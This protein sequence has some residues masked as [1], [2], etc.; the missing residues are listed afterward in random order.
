MIARL[1]VG[2]SSWQSVSGCNHRREFSRVRT[3]G[4]TT[5]ARLSEE[6]IPLAEQAI[7]LSP[8]DP[9]IGVPYSLIGTIHLLQSHIAAAIV[10][11]EKARSAMPRSPL[12][13]SRLAS[14]YALRGETECAS[15]E[16]TEVRRL[17]GGHLFSSIAHLKA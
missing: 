11:L 17:S 14:A 8:R 6:V 12:H 1:D 9:L 10:W 4:E 2:M 13:R 5:R 16:L 3:R 15:A 7:R